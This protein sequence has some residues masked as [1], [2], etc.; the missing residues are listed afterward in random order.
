MA[1]V[2]TRRLRD[3]GKRLGLKR[4]S[5]LDGVLDVFDLSLLF[6]TRR[7]YRPHRNPWRADAEAIRSD[8]EAVGRDL[9]AAFSHYQ[10]EV[11]RGRTKEEVR[12]P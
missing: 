8:F 9:W 6:G 12:K 2:T 3:Y 4:F 11:A 7:L 1:N 5:F 10:A